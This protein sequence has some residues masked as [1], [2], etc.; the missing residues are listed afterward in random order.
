M[1]KLLLSALPCAFCLLAVAEDA[2][3]VPL[4]QTGELP[5]DRTPELLLS[6]ERNPF[7]RRETKI[8]ETTA[9]GES[10]ESKLRALLGAMTVRGVIR[11]DGSVKVL[12][13]HFI[14]KQ[15]EPIPPLFDDQT[16][17][18]FVK[19]ITDKQVEIDFIE[20]EKQAEPRKI[21][22]LIDLRPRVGV[23]MAS[24]LV[25][26]K[27]STGLIK[28]RPA[29][30][31][32]PRDARGA[33]NTHAMPPPAGTACALGFLAHRAPRGGSAGG[34]GHHGRRNDL[35][36]P[37]REQRASL[38]LWNGE[39]RCGFGQF[40]RHRKYHDR[41]VLRAELRTGGAGRGRP[42]PVHRRS[43]SRVGGLLPRPQWAQYY[44][45]RY[46]SRF[47]FLPG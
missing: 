4:S 30:S 2:P 15:G 22:I 24:T 36:K 27:T 47:W 44:P 5:D 33:M 12:L 3:R 25:K 9:D 42:R 28:V 6:K 29:Y 35:P 7:I 38:E 16:E 21:L 10:E 37:H 14:L 1:R 45:T 8:A 17:H 39:R 26:S 46:D 18:L 32:V 13:E 43:S 40:L 19:R 31:E 41:Y 23:R 11:G 34:G 20:S